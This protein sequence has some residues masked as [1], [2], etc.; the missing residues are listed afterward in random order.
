MYL[1][2]TIGLK[3]GLS[4]ALRV[5][6]DAH[7]F[8]IFKSKFTDFKNFDTQVLFYTFFYRTASHWAFY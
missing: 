8:E 6:D 5:Q 1:L 3:F 4:K 7:V 2:M